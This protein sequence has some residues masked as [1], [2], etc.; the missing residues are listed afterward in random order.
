MLKVKNKQ[1]EFQAQNQ[2][3]ATNADS[4]PRPNL[5]D[6]GHVLV[7]VEHYLFPSGMSV[8]MQNLLSHFHP[9]SYSVVTVNNPNRLG[10]EAGHQ[11]KIYPIMTTIRRYSS[12]LD[13]LWRDWQLSRAVSKMVD[14]V[15]QTDAKLIIGVYPG[16]H[17]LKIARETAKVTGVPWIAYLHDTVA[18]ALSKTRRAGKA[19]ELQAQ[20]FAEANEVVVMSQGMTD[21][22]KRNYNLNYRPLEHTYPE[23]IPERI[24]NWP[25]M[26][27]AFWG[28]AIYN[29]NDRAVAR[30][31]EALRLIDCP[32]LLTTTA[33][34][35]ALEQQGIAGGHIR[36]NFYP[37]RAAYLNA[38][39][40]QGILILAL[41]WPDET[42]QHEEELGTIFPTKTPEYLAAGR[43]II[44][45]CPEH[46]F[47]ARYFRQTGAGL[48][49]SERSVE[50]LAKAIRHL[51]ADSAEARQMRQ[52]ALAAAHQFSAQ[53]IASRF[54]AMVQ[55][56][57]QSQ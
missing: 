21:F 31:S 56:I 13:E 53:R 36:T 5:Y 17:F 28:G 15:A 51:L 22:Y 25:A 4:P 38:L 24:T 54:Q 34:P 19:A 48:V 32:F 9:A 27:H 29:I 7:A 1:G 12:R 40:R 30:V 2:L 33:T 49:V 46:Y 8:T 57:A 50:A 3:Q 18:E 6:A 35:K 20:V 26:R 14:V 10:L 55:A 44:V 45:H 47:L 41:N 42:N 11:A 52:A 37:S 23:P 39:Q 16:Y 43:P